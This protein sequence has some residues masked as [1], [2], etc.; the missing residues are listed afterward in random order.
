MPEGS[1]VIQLN[2]EANKDF[3]IPPLLSSIAGSRFTSIVGKPEKSRNA[4]NLRIE[5]I[6]ESYV[7]KPQRLE[8]VLAFLNQ[9]SNL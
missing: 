2:N 3:I 9:S 6:H 8:T 1:H 5:Q 4:R 7:I